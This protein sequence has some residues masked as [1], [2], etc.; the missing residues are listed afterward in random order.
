MPSMAQNPKK[1]AYALHSRANVH[2]A[3]GNLDATLAT[4]APGGPE[5]RTSA[6]GSAILPPDVDRTHRAAERTDRRRRFATYQQ[7][8]ELSRRARHAEG[9]AQSLRTLGEVLFELGR[10]EEALPYLAEAA[11]LFAQLEDA[12]AEADLWN[13]AAAAHERTGRHAESLRRVE[14]RPAASPA[15]RAIRR[16]VERAGRHRARPASRPRRDGCERG[17]VRRRARDG[18][19]T[20]RMAPGARLPQHAWHPGMDPG[21][22]R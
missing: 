14:A 19:H 15:G 4:P 10:H 3:M 17:G 1:L 11:E 16:S 9:L 8:I 6:A 7:A 13:R 12:A 20:G 21:S 18:V 2:R 5:L 22:F